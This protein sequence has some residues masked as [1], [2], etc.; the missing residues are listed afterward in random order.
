MEDELLPKSFSCSTPSSEEPED[1]SPPPPPESV[2]VEI[3]GPHMR[4][5]KQTYN[6]AWA[7]SALMF[8]VMLMCI[9]IVLWYVFTHN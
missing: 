3:P 7:A 2:A 1:E 6:A 5:P 8:L 4:P 9:C